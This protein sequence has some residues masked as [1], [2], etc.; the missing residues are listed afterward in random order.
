MGLDFS[1]NRDALEELEE[2]L[3]VCLCSKSYA[4]FF[5]ESTVQILYSSA[6]NEH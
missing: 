1:T 5:S 3:Q 2:L 4:V 6:C